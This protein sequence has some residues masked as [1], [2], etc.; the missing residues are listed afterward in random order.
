MAGTFPGVCNTQQNGIN[1]EPLA[2]AILTIYNGGTTVLSNTFQDIG[3]AIP[4]ANPMTADSSGRLPLIFVAD[5]VYRVRLTDQFGSTANGGFDYPQVPSIG[6]SSSG[7]GGTAVDPTTVLSTGDTKWQL[8]NQ[9]IAGFVRLNGKTLGGPTSGASERANNDTQAL[10]AYLW[11]NF[12]DAFCPV[13]GGRGYHALP[14]ILAL[15]R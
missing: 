5:G 11:Q 1:G 14:Q 2:A 13:I 6:A 7:G 10:Y 12:T 4:A 15:R 8:I 9:P 3:L